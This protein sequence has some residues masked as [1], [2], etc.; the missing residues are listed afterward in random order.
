MSLRRNA[1]LRQGRLRRAVAGSAVVV[2]AVLVAGCGGGS[3]GGAQADGFTQAKQSTTKE[4]TVWVDSTRQAAAAAYQ[5][6]HP[7]VKLD[8]VTYD[9][10]ANGSNFLQTKVQLFNRTGSGWPDV[11]WSTQTNETAWAAKGD[12]KF[13][14]PLNKGL[15]PDATLSGFAKG[16]LDTCT[17]D[18]TVYCLRN[19]LAQVVLWYDQPLMAQ[20]GYTV[21]TT[22]EEYETLGKRVAA[23]H[24]GYN[25][26]D[27][28]DAFAPEIYFWASKCPV[29]TLTDATTLKVDSA[30]PEC[31]RMASLI[32]T[33]HQ[34]G[35]ITSTGVFSNDYAKSQAAKTLMLPGPSWFGGALFKDTFKTPGGRIAVG[36]ALHWAADKDQPVTGNVGGGTWLLSSHSTHLDLAVEFMTFMTT[37][38]AYQVELA[39]GYPAFS[40]AAQGWLKKQASSGYFAGD[41]GPPMIDAATRVWPGWGSP[42]FSQEKIWASTITPGVTAGKTI[43]SLLPDWQTSIINYAKANGYRIGQ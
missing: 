12:N 35:S 22:W 25:V 8:I 11:V 19:D 10:D 28:G 2:A 33:L 5:K 3:E 15:V 34:A 1:G 24:P 4:L 14:A 38:D 23:E 20:F 41:I 30:A 16:S 29:N 36:P 9:G 17:V 18:G 37:D 43:T 21:P 42:S 6:A 26:G 39:P 40:A 13:T 7:D 32:D 31:T 27:I